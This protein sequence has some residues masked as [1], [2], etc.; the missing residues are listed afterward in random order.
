MNLMCQTNTLFCRIISSQF[1]YKWH[2]NILA[3]KFNHAN[4]IESISN[5]RHRR[6][7]HHHYWHVRRSI[8]GD[9]CYDFIVAVNSQFWKHYRPQ[10]FIFVLISL[11]VLFEIKALIPCNT[12]CL[13]ICCSSL[14]FSDLLFLFRAILCCYAATVSATK[15]TSESSANGKGNEQTNAEEKCPLKR[16]YLRIVSIFHFRLVKVHRKMVSDTLFLFSLLCIR[17]NLNCG[18]SE[19]VDRANERKERWTRK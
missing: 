13:F 5:D 2:V 19:S 7:W 14:Y 15:S 16:I 4:I 3:I 9:S 18:K 8:K 12:S 1:P 10:F 17:R 11:A 6:D